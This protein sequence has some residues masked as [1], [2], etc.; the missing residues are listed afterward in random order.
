MRSVLYLALSALAAVAVADSPNPFNIPGHGY[1][2]T[3]GEPTTLSWSPTTEGTVTLKLLTGAVTN[4]KDGTT[5]ASSIP[6]SG[7]YQWTPPS[8]IAAEPDYT[9]EIINDSD[10][11]QY[12]FLPRFVVAGATGT[13]TT[14][15]AT[16]ASPTTL[17]TKASTTSPTSAAS[18]TSGTTSPASSTTGASTTTGSASTTSA[19]ASTTS[20]AAASTSSAAASSTT[21]APNMN[22][23]GITRVSV[24]MMAVVAGAIAFI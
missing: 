24:G 19:A 14:S 18:T 16:T 4:P 11:S 23:A 21:S 12:N 22:G 7:S 20:G 1:T 13:S 17:T 9:I 3:V 2:F 8:D 15:A 10:P 5:I 6:N